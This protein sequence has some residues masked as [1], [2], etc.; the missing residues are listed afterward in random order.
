MEEVGHVMLLLACS[1]L[2]KAFDQQNG[3][4][5]PQ[6]RSRGE[7]GVLKDLRSQNVVYAY[8]KSVDSLLTVCGTEKEN[9]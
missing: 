7:S 1:R 2:P 3:L 8:G 4:K 9:S 5:H 6:L